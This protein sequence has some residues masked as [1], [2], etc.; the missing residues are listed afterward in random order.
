VLAVIVSIKVKLAADGCSSSQQ[1]V[2]RLCLVRVTVIA[3]DNT[4]F[5]AKVVS[6]STGD[7]VGLFIIL[8]FVQTF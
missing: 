5:F 6:A 4:P 1:C 2:R 3:Q 8:I 7:M